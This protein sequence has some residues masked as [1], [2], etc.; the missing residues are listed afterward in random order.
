MNKA[1]RMNGS[2]SSKNWAKLSMNAN[3][4][5]G[6]MKSK[7][8]KFD[9]KGKDEGTAHQNRSV[10]GTKRGHIDGPNQGMGT[11]RHGAGPPSRAG[12]VH[13]NA[14]K[15]GHLDTHQKPS[16]PR[17]GAGSSRKTLSHQ[18]PA[19]TNETIGYP[20]GGPSSRAEAPISVRSRR[21]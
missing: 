13:G 19:T 11:A 2:I 3:G 8:A 4:K 12:G 18:Q 14:G 20:Y 21:Q 6:K 17:Q 1:L 16:F 7:M 9:A 10:S 5:G 15:I